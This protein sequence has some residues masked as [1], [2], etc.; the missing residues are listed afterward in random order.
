MIL[1]FRDHIGPQQ[2]WFLRSA[3]AA[4]TPER[5]TE[6]VL[7]ESTKNSLAVLT[8]SGAAL[9]ESRPE[10]LRQ[11]VDDACRIA[12]TWIE[13]IKTRRVPAARAWLDEVSR[14]RPR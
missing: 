4:D 7:E 2:G 13:E 5:V 1:G 14:D 10:E 12:S 3:L 8:I 6:I 9:T 11:W